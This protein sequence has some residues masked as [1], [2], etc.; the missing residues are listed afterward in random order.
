MKHC[1]TTQRTTKRTAVMLS[2]ATVVLLGLTVCSSV[3]AEPREGEVVLGIRLRLGWKYDNLRVCGATPPGVPH[4]PDI[5]I[6]FFSEV[7]L[8]DGVGLD[9]NV[10]MFRPIMFAASARLLQF[11]PEVTLVF[12]K[13]VSGR[14]VFQG[15][16]ALGVSLNYAPDLN[17][18]FDSGRLRPSFFSIGPRIGGYVGFDFIRDG[19]RFNDQLGFHPYVLPL[20]AIRDPARHRGLVL[21]GTIDNSFRIH[22]VP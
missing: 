11:E 14:T 17:A 15:G 3:S 10:P 21:G 1:I 18:D 7:G 22:L 6:S 20:V 4:G 12:S 8:K 19:K 16:P 5:D 9:I 13:E 2:V